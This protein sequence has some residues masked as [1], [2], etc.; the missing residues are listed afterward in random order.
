MLNLVYIFKWVN[1]INF[2]KL[3]KQQVIINNIICALAMVVCSLILAISFNVAQVYDLQITDIHANIINQVRQFNLIVFLTR[4]I[5]ILSILGFGYLYY[6]VNK[7]K[8]EKNKNN[9]K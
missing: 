7:P 5:A 4:A 3:S 8:L 2:S 9:I 1:M 6:R